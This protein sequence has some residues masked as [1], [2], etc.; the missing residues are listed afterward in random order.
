MN[1]FHGWSSGGRVGITCSGSRSEWGCA[2]F[3]R[4]EDYFEQYSRPDNFKHLDY[5]QVSPSENQLPPVVCLR[6]DCQPCK[7]HKSSPP[8]S[9][10]L[11][12]FDDFPLQLLHWGPPARTWKL[13]TLYIL[14]NIASLYCFKFGWVCDIEDAVPHTSNVTCGLLSHYC[15][16]LEPVCP[17][18]PLT[19][20]VIEGFTST[21][22]VFAGFILEL[23]ECNKR[24]HGSSFQTSLASLASRTVSSLAPPPSLARDWRHRLRTLLRLTLNCLRGDVSDAEKSSRP[25]SRPPKHPGAHFARLRGL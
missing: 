8:V 21:R 13:I 7:I 15:R 16:G 24:L 3:K 10:F 5:F 6:N 14:I 2:R 23:Y 4:G 20:G 9:L 11:D 22:M 12:I 25:P 18:G 1:F 19:G 17:S